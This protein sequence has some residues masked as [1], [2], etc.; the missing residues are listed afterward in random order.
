[1]TQA[2]DAFGFAS[3][4]KETFAARDAELRADWRRSLPFGDAM[5]DRWD[6]AR[7]LGFGDGTSVYD[8]A[9]VFGDVSVG[10]NVWIGPW[11]M[12]D[13][14]GGLAIGDHVSISAGVHVY[15]HDTVHWALS[16]GQL[17]ARKGPV[18]IGSCVYIGSQSVIA[19][20]VTI[21]SRSVVSANSLVLDDVPEA[22]IVGG[23][24]A[25]RIGS[26]EG[27]GAHVQLKF[28]SSQQL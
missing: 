16:K 5:F 18:S 14:S 17:P 24:P 26:V 2:S 8:S 21:G 11:V 10:K 1:M 25:R 22:A 28:D 13:G 7:R 3:L 20:G 23:T 27:D 15:T 9:C 12:L 6:K 19:L 4:L